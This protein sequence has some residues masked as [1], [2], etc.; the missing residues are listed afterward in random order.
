MRR[1]VTSIVLVI[2]LAIA[3]P[4]FGQ[5]QPPPQPPA[6]APEQA[7]SGPRDIVPGR[8][9]AGIAI[10]SAITTV[11]AR[12]GRPAEI[13][14]TA[15]D[16]F[17]SFSRLGI[18]VYARDAI[19]TAVSTTN[20]LMS[21]NREVGVGYRRE[22]AVRMFG[23]QFREGIVEGF[24]GPV[25][26]ARGIA[27]GIDINAVAVVLVFRPGAAAAVSGLLPAAP[28]VAQVPPSGFPN[29]AG[30]HPFTAEANYMSLPGYLR[31]LVYQVSGRWITY[32]EAKRIVADQQGR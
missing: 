2:I 7:P 5:Q 28:G 1:A 24:R 22:D 30:L 16:T 25:Y 10:G 21:V 4:A 23:G 20:S 13:R 29:V 14:E 15:V 27:F 3:A 19:V 6:P 8:S 9:I 17:Y 18:G 11:L 12:F 26:D 31:W 32:A